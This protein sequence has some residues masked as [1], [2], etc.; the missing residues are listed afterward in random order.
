MKFYILLLVAVLLGG[1]G[2][3]AAGCTDINAPGTVTL[4]GNIV[5]IGAD[6]DCIYINSSDVVFDC[7]GFYINDSNSTDYNTAILLEDGYD[8]ITVKN[9][10]LY[11]FEIGISVGKNKFVAI[12]NNNI[13]IPEG[14]STSDTTAISFGGKN[15]NISNNRI[16]Y[17]SVTN[18]NMG[19]FFAGSVS[20]VSGNDVNGVSKSGFYFT[21]G[22]SEVNVTGNNA[23]FSDQT[24]YETNDASFMLFKENTAY[25]CSSSGFVINGVANN[26]TNNTARYNSLQGPNHAGFTITR[27]GIIIVIGA[28]TAY[29]GAAIDPTTYVTDNIA[30]HNNGNGFYLGSELADSRINFSNN[31]ANY[32]LIGINVQS[33]NNVLTDNTAQENLFAD[34]FVGGQNIWEGGPFGIFTAQFDPLVCQNSI[35]RTIGSG[36]RPIYFA[37]STTTVPVG[38]YS[39]IILC[40]A[41]DS[42]LDRVTVDGSDTLGNN[43]AVI[44]GS[45]RTTITDSVSHDNAVGFWLYDSIQSNITRGSAYNNLV[46]GYMLAGSG[47]TVLKDLSSYNNYGNL[48]ELV[49][50]FGFDGGKGVR[51]FDWSDIP[52]G[53]GVLDYTTARA[54]SAISYANT[55]N[56][57]RIYNNAY[58]IALLGQGSESPP[59][60]P[61]PPP[62]FSSGFETVIVTPGSPTTPQIINSYIFENRIFGVIDASK[63]GANVTDSMIYDNGKDATELFNLLSGGFAAS[64]WQT[65][66][67]ILAHHGPEGVLWTEY[68]QGTSLVSELLDL[69]FPGTFTAPT[70]LWQMNHTKIGSQNGMTIS[71]QDND[72]ANGESFLLSDTN[73]P[74][75]QRLQYQDYLGGHECTST[76][77]DPEAQ[78]CKD[79]Q[80]MTCDDMYKWVGGVK[81]A[82]SDSIC[83]WYQFPPEDLFGARECLDVNENGWCD[84]CDTYNV[85]IKFDWKNPE[86]LSSY[87]NQ[88]LMLVSNYADDALSAPPAAVLDEFAAWWT[89]SECYDGESIA[90]YYLQGSE[91]N[92][93]DEPEPGDTYYINVSGN[94]TYLEDQTWGDDTISVQELTPY[95]QIP[96]AILPF[97]DSPAMGIYGL[98]A[99][100][101]QCGE[102][103]GEPRLHISLDSN[104][105]ENTVTVTGEHG[106]VAG[107]HVTVIN[108]AGS[109]VDAG[110]A[111]A[112]GQFTFEDCGQAVYITANAG[113]YDAGE[114]SST[115]LDSCDCVPTGCVPECTAGQQCI[116]GQC[117]GEPECTPAC[118]TDQQ[119]EN[120]QCM[121]A[122]DCCADS[123]CAQ[124][125]TCV[126][127]TCTKPEQP[128]CV[129][130]ADCKGTEYCAIAAG[131]AGGTCENVP[132][133]CGYADNHVWVSY[134]CGSETGCPGCPQGES[135]VNRECKSGDVTCPT[136]GVVGEATTCTAR[137]GEQPCVSCDYQ[138]TDPAGKTSSGKSDEDGNFQVPLGIEGTYTVTLFKDGQPIKTI[139]VKAFPK[140]APVEPEKPTAAPDA[141]TTLL[142]LLL[143][144]ALIILA[145]LYW[146]SQGG[147]KAK[148]PEKKGKK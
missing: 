20:T 64:Q 66:A 108:A 146:R 103:G 10:K 47:G 56:N 133:Q 143:L 111:D 19:I 121:C 93:S 73:I 85:D 29:G 80:D 26:V 145:V 48:S 89:P 53:F 50:M 28:R 27:P 25:N 31:K 52:L 74:T 138:I 3:A 49:G 98:F 65:I 130:D 117:I 110:Y 127:H 4:P 94:W 24:G 68:L 39:G 1:F 32:N 128:E 8:N 131:A 71:L 112:A 37:N 46:A 21:T 114:M 99:A 40:N 88:Y 102:D 13:S 132:G 148:P 118:G 9:C 126:D 79:Y 135:C 141:G 43:G 136:T 109:I 84:F 72:I 22:V 33:Y 134:A 140:S 63:Q 125:E 86:G 61:P 115:M 35:E 101:L 11:N 58:G 144:L 92:T 137:D 30:E 116:D 105:N 23:Q 17:G 60:P 78:K 55:Y 124:G 77:C 69:F 44:I 119:C 16:G 12:T 139:E 113:G 95:W 106:P 83:D 38:T 6:P 87:Q 123:D 18:Y 5:D 59:P 147:K 70:A 107:A 90:L 62:G 67:N 45:P 15:G 96:P 75:I 76:D 82:G 57:V 129:T 104:C 91:V 100:P 142:F 34:L 36:G 122:Y 14:T 2:F 81:T 97:M 51:S 42:V 54:F 120:S 7:Q 41:S